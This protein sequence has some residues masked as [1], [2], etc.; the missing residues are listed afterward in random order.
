[1]SDP[2]SSLFDRSFGAITAFLIP[3]LIALFGIATVNP[4]V[5]SWFGGAQTAPTLVGFLFVMAAALALT[6]VITSLRW[7]L[8]EHVRWPLRKG[9]LVTPAP[10]FDQSQRRD[11]EA[12]YQDIRYQHYYHYLSSTN[13]AVA[14]QIAVWT[15]LIGSPGALALL[16]RLAIL[17]G[18]VGAS[19]VLGA[20]GCNAIARYDEKMERLLGRIPTAA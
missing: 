5:A 20:A 10:P 9:P 12:A 3:G 4:T 17:S 16:P 18:A 11:R 6:T 13:C 15:W 2:T 19:L 7:L 8:F 14:I 1:M